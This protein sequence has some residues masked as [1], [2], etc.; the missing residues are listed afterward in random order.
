MANLQSVISESIYKEPLLL[1]DEF[2]RTHMLSGVDAV[3]SRLI[4]LMYMEPGTIRDIYNMGIN[5][6]KYLFDRIDD[7]G[8]IQQDINYQLST[9]L[10]M[11][12]LLLNAI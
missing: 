1:I 11:A 9:T 3:V 5:I 12:V 8:V 10:S 7:V 6:K 4:T 2:K